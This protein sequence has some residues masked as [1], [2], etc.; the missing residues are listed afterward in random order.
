MN[1]NE[2]LTTLKKYEL[3]DK[4]DRQIKNNCQSKKIVKVKVKVIGF[5]VVFK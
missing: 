3:D 5:G 2:L 4:K 1:L